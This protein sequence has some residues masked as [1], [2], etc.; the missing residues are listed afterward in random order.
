MWYCVKIEVETFDCGQDVRV[1]IEVE[2]LIFAFIFSLVNV[3]IIF[4]LTTKKLTNSYYKIIYIT[5]GRT[6][7]I[8]AEA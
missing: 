8:W 4:F 5:I 3:I 7:R 6:L 1:K 2:V